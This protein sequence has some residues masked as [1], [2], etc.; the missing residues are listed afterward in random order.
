MPNPSFEQHSSCP[1]GAGELDKAEQ[2]LTI[3]NTPDYFNVC[4]TN[5]FLG[6]CGVPDNDFGFQYP[7]SENC[8]SFA[9]LFTY[10]PLSPNGREYLGI[11]L[12]HPLVIGQTYYISLKASLASIESGASNNLGI[13]FRTYQQL[14]GPFDPN[15]NFSHLKS[16]LLITDTANWTTIF[17]SFV[18]D[19]SYAYIEIG[20]FYDDSLTQLTS[21]DANPYYFIDDVCISTDSIYSA[22]YRFDCTPQDVERNN[23]EKCLVYPNPVSDVLHIQSSLPIS[24]VN[25]YNPLGQCM[26]HGYNLSSI[27]VKEFPLGYYFLELKTL[28]NYFYRKILVN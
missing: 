9:G 22:S 12:I 1:D 19:S 21:F 20:N 6:Y 2:W 17:G 16:A 14:Q 23:R 13:L 8:T 25:I 5:T 4:A 26:F 15:N 3:R 10:A 24:E 28:D 11:S 27:S 18:A 7:P